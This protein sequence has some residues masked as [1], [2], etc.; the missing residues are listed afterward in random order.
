MVSI[1]RSL[2]FVL[3]WFVANYIIYHSHWMKKLFRTQLQLLQIVND[4]S[5]VD[6]DVGIYKLYGSWLMSRGLLV[7]SE[8]QL[9]SIVDSVCKLPESKFS[10]LERR[11][12]AK[13]TN[14][15]KI[16]LLQKGSSAR[17]SNEKRAFVCAF[18]MLLYLS[19]HINCLHFL[20]LLSVPLEFII[21]QFFTILSEIFEGK[22]I[23]RNYLGRKKFYLQSNVQH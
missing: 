21:W 11:I 13:F 16:L 4:H 23:N 10:T 1:E 3:L 19:S 6:N 5:R 9:C 8:I 20:V 22:L 7:T 12:K 17:T 15:S 2:F 14:L 18:A